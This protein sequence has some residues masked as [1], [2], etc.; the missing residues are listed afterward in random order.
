MLVI[1]RASQS[2][3]AAHFEPPDLRSPKKS[4]KVKVKGFKSRGKCIAVLVA[5]GVEVAAT[6]ALQICIFQ[7]VRKSAETRALTAWIVDGRRAG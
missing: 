3:A 7:A 6:E 2:V 4:A 5:K 1:V